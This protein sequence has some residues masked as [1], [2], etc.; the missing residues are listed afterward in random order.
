MTVTSPKDR[1][2][3]LRLMAG[4]PEAAGASSCSEKSAEAPPAVA[5]S[6]ALSAALTA[7]TVARNVALDAFAETF[8][9][10]GRVTAELVLDKVTASP[11]APAAPASVTV[12]RSVP[13]PVMLA[14]LQVR[15]RTAWV[16][17]CEPGAFSLYL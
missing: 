12:Q 17:C 6:V 14:L 15:L 3:V 4:D 7:D 9:E 1:L 16:V 13:A 2:V 11:P 10:A 8:T 5:V